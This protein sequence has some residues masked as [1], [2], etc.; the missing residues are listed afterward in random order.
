ME[1]SSDTIGIRTC[2]L[3]ASSALDVDRIQLKYYTRR[4]NFVGLGTNSVLHNEMSTIGRLTHCT[5]P[6]IIIS[7]SVLERI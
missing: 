2:G 6:S 1:N 3:P 7:A 4:E 5:A